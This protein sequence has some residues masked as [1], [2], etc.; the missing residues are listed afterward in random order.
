[1]SEIDSEN[2]ELSKTNFDLN[3]VIKKTMSNHEKHASGR[4]VKIIFEQKR[5]RLKQ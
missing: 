4:N 2:F 5:R 3:E 1:V